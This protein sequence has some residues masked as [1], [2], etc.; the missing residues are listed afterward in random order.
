MALFHFHATQIKRSAGQSAIA[1][2]AY[3]SG[4]KFRSEYYNEVSDYT[5]KEGVVHTEIL[6]PARA[7]PRFA[8][9]ETLWNEVEKVEKNKKAQLA[10]SFDIALQNEFSLEENIALARQFLLDEFVSRGMIVDFSVHQ[11]ERDGIAN[12]HFHVLCPIRPLKEDGSWDAKQRRVYVENEDGTRALDDAGHAIFNAVPTTDWGRPETLEH[13]REVWAQLCNAKFAEKQLDCSIDNRSFERQ[14]LDLLPTIHEGPAVRQMEAKGIRTNK[15]DLNRWIQS[16][17]RLIKDMKR[18]IASL[19]S[20]IS[21]VKEELSKPQ[22]PNMGELLNAYYDKRN[23]GAYSKAARARNLTELSE[24]FSFIM[25]RKL[26]TV[27]DLEHQ[28]N[29]LRDKVNALQSSMKAKST[30]QKE[31]KEVLH[32]AE[33]YRQYKPVFDAMN[34][35]RFKKKRESY[36]QAHEVELR[37]FY[38][39]RRKLQAF[40]G[41]DG[42]ISSSALQKEIAMLQKDYET[43]YA[44]LKPLRE[45]LRQL[46][47]IKSH[48]DTVLREDQRREQEVRHSQEANR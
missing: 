30:R 12:P 21:A 31:L 32:Q 14:G 48:V 22:P 3:R 39:A 10:Y 41:K 38:M 34:A 5:R 29:N 11:P 25:A 23:A 15:G 18:K 19:L 44:E 13:W 36:R 45:E 28:V 17:N 2:A 46:W 35:I 20:W 8:D 1:A 6:L 47:K 43:E 33:N 27:D 4:E 24:A 16:T 40:A 42:K 7:P 26:Y 9:R 37:Q